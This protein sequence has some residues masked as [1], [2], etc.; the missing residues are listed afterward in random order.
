MCRC[1]ANVILTILGAP[2]WR[3][4][5]S[6]HEPGYLSAD[7]DEPVAASSMRSANARHSA[8][9]VD[10]SAHIDLIGVPWLMTRAEP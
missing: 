5:R 7:R 9:P 4:G 1:P 2:V 8:D 6:Y 3:S 10:V